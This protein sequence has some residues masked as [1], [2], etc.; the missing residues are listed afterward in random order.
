MYLDEEGKTE[1][2]S[3]FVNRFL[4]SAIDTAINAKNDLRKLNV[5]FQGGLG[6]SY[7]I[8]RGKVFVEGGGNI[9]FLYIQ[10]GDEHG[11]NNI[12][13]VLYW[14]VMPTISGERK[15]DYFI[16]IFSP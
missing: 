9:G 10:K 2:P 11:K 5:G 8:G 4:G 7:D 15:P 6:L 16:S 12:G 14:W 1:I 3:I 13:A